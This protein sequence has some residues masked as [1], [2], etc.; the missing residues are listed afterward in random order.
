MW[1]E[2]IVSSG[3][4]DQAVKSG[5]ATRDDLSRMSRAWQA[6]SEADDGWFAIVHGEILCRP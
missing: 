4:A 5:L 6:W 1:S 2:R 3:I